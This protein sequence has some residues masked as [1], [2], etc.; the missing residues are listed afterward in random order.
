MDK[1]LCSTCV[2]KAG[3]PRRDLNNDRLLALSDRERQGCHGRGCEDVA[4]FGTL[5]TLILD[6][7]SD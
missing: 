6:A 3:I 2:S 1:S 5:K 4:G 7:N